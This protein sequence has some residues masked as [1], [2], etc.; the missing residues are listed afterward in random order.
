[1]LPVCWQPLHSMFTSRKQS[2]FE[3]KLF[4]VYRKFLKVTTAGP[5]SN[6]SIGMENNKELYGI[7][8]VKVKLVDS[9]I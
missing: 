8:A 6:S 3:W 9:L 4:V 2:G 1:M 7:S 5:R